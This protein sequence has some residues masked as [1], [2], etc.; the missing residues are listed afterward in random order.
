[1]TN[2]ISIP[3]TPTDPSYATGNRLINVNTLSAVFATGTAQ[4]TLYTTGE[5]FVLV[6]TAAKGVDVV[7]AIN[8]AIAAVPGG[9]V[10]TVDLPAGVKI[11]SV[12]TS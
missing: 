7:N 10:V 8:A 5:N 6:T 12:T 1:M 4:V 9:Q 3:V 11:T 2:F